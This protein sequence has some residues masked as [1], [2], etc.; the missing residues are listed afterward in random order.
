MSRKAEYGVQFVG[1]SARLIAREKYGREVQYAMLNFVSGLASMNAD[2]GWV[3][4]PKRVDLGPF[5]RSL[6]NLAGELRELLCQHAAKVQQES[7]GTDVTSKMVS[8]SCGPNTVSVAPGTDIDRFIQQITKR[9]IEIEQVLEQA[10]QIGS[11]IKRRPYFEYLDEIGGT[12]IVRVESHGFGLFIDGKL[13]FYPN[14]QVGFVKQ[15]GSNIFEIHSLEPKMNI[16]S[17]SN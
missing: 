13:I 11:R 2:G 12:G 9:F 8:L 3:M 15:R 5:L 4:V 1:Y 6:P 17:R 10:E 14:Y 7:V 16:G